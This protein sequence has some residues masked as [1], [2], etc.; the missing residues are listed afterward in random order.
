MS[1]IPQAYEAFSP[2]IDVPPISIDAV[3]VGDVLVFIESVPKP[4]DV[5]LVDAVPVFVDSVPIFIDVIPVDVVS[6]FIDPAPI[7]IDSVPVSFRV[8]V[9]E[10]EGREDLARGEG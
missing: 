3:P 8:M 7:S 5:V 4:M 2:S 1:S 9:R 10:A 6:V